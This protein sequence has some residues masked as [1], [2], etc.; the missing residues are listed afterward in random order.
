MKLAARFSI[1]A[2]V[3][4]TGIFV[5]TAMAQTLHYIQYPGATDTYVLA[6]TNQP[7]SNLSAVV[8]YYLD[9]AGAKHGFVLQ[10]GKYAT[11]DV[12]GGTDTIL[13]GVKGGNTGTLLIVGSYTAP[14]GDQ[15]FG[16]MDGVLRLTN[17]PGAVQ[18][19]AYGDSSPSFLLIAGDYLDAA[20]AWHG[21]VANG[22]TQDPVYTILDVPGAVGS[23]ATNASKNGWVTLQW[24]DA[25]GHTESSLYQSQTFT[26]IDVP[27]A[28]DSYAH[29][30]D[31]FGNV[32][33]SWLDAQGKTHGAVL[34]HKTGVYTTV[35]PA[36]CVN[37]SANGINDYHVL[38]G[39][40]EKADGHSY[41]FW[42]VF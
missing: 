3:L 8:G 35:D 7:S 40:C 16:Y 28:T 18:S 33:F 34:T 20:G 14:T 29:A 32:A 10:G 13:W 31:S 6:V 26:T 30:V 12:R 21:Y 42:L 39:T 15:G 36:D 4:I 37:T 27:N 9:S 23:H 38:V 22:T 25:N 1:Q 17:P 11:L 24:D 2:M 5:S 19:H 41:G